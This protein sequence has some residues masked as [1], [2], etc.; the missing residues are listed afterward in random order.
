[1]SCRVKKSVKRNEIRLHA[2]PRQLRRRIEVSL[3]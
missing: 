2:G 3:I 1:M